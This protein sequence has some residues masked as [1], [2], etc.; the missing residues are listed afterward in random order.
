M[1]NA[2][3]GS[4][5]SLLPW[6]IAFLV[7]TV[8][9]SARG[10]QA[11]IERAVKFMM[12]ALFVM[13]I[14][15]V[16]YAALV[17]DFGRAASFLFRPDFSK[18]D[19]RTVLAA[20]GAAFFSVSVGITNMMAYGAYVDRTT[21]LPGTA[22]IVVAADTVVALLA[23]LAIFPLIFE[24]GLQPSGGPGLVFMTLPI[25]F[26]QIPG[27]LI[28]GTLFFVLLF[29]AALTSSIGMLEAPVSWLRG[30]NESVTALGGTAGRINWACAWHTWRTFFPARYRTFTRWARLRCLRARPF[31]IPTYTSC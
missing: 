19:S 27:G 4:P 28:F 5:G 22:T 13:L 3:N 10:L 29:F 17:G 26:G 8:I 21:R 18:L 25:A 15:M 9:I 7:A 14:A 11:G 12:P 31:S 23:G 24:Y 1:F 30:R 20:F 6:V 16:V 2:L